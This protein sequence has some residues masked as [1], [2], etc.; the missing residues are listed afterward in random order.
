M[1]E[2]FYRYARTVD[3]GLVI[4]SA[5]RTFQEQAMLYQRSQAGQNNGLPAMPPGT[6]DHEIG[7]A[8]DMARPG[9][10][11]LGD[12][13]LPMLG[14]TWLRWGGRWNAIDPVHFAAPRAIRDARWTSR[15]VRPMRRTS[16]PRGRSRR[17]RRAR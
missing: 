7:M 3:R 11:P 8:F 5:R 6:S 12:Y 14:Q 10:E 4:T 16:L 2:K 9:H 13:L 17:A 1:A 15:S